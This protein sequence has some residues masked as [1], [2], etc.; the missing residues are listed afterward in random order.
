MTGEE[1]PVAK[2]EFTLTNLSGRPEGLGM[3][4]PGVKSLPLPDGYLRRSGERKNPA[5]FL[6][7]SSRSNRLDP[8]D[9]LQW[10]R[11]S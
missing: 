3:P 2:E 8:P 6:H 7:Q 1:V 9:N 4:G 5:M 10:P 11:F